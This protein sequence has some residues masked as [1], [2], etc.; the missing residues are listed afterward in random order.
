MPAWR[1]A[2]R[3]E[4]YRSAIY[5]ISLAILAIYFLI[6]PIWRAQ[7]PLEI[8]LTEGWNAYLQ[9]AAAS[10][11]QLY[12]SA[13]DLIGNNYPPLSFY[14][15]GFLGKLFG[16]SLYVGRALSIAG[17]LCVAGEIFLCARIL[18]GT[19]VGPVTGALWYVAIMAHNSTA[20]VGA[21]DP[22]IAGEAIMGAALVLFLKR[23]G[24]GRSVVPALL[25][26]VVGGFWKH[27]M[28]AIP[29]TAIAWLLWRDR[30]RACGPVLISAAATVSGLLFCRLCFGRAFFEDLL[31]PRAY[32]WGG[33]L[34]N[35]GHLQWCVPAL[36]IWAVWAI[37]NRGS[38][39]ARFTLLHVGIGLAACIL[40][41]SG[42][43]VSGNAEFDLLLALGIAVA[44]TFA[45]MERSWFARHVRAD[46]L[47][48]LM[49]IALIIR[50]IAADRQE[51]FLVFSSAAFSS[52]FYA[53]A[54][55]VAKEA[56]EVSSIPGD[57]FC[58]NKLVCRLAGKPFV[59]DDFK[60]EE[61]VSTGRSTQDQ[62]ETM[63]RER[64]I[65][66]FNNARMTRVSPNTSL[67]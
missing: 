46:Y 16:D 27:N 62:I 4:S 44:V 2:P 35:V 21:N 48:D 51:T 7:F 63:L 1:V 6:W 58:T 23:D 39:A 13:N 43:G 24:A 32:G 26:M 49:V 41:W 8:W 34:A 18:T 40:Q 37:G 61:M 67:F 42:E 65:T 5:L 17:L 56:S 59:A 50:L 38:T 15:I 45:R 20:Y 3:A 57:V 9:D 19:I 14:T 29:L 28:I 60:L 53:G 47:R 11:G 31:A 52:Y 10:G 12:P 64:G 33:I 25:L 55:D 30:S 54:R 22:Q 66:R 36:V